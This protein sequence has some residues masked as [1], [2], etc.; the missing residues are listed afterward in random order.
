MADKQA[1]SSDLTFWRIQMT[2]AIHNKFLV[3]LYVRPSGEPAHGKPQK[4]SERLAQVRINNG[5]HVADLVRECDL[6]RP[7]SSSVL[8]QVIPQVRP[9]GVSLGI[10]RKIA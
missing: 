9:E 7:S 2:R 6:T 1:A 10:Q 3:N 8:D 4:P 5:Q